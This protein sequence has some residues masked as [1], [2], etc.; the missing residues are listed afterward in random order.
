MKWVEGLS[1]SAI[2]VTAAIAAVQCQGVRSQTTTRTEQAIAAMSREVTVVINGQNPGSG[3]IVARNG[4]TY[5]VLTA[6]HAIATED[7]YQIVTADAASHPIDYRNVTKLP[8]VDLAIAK[9]TSST[10]YRVAQLGNSDQTL[11]GST[12]YVSGWPHPGRVLTDRI[13]QISKGTISGRPLTA[14]EDGYG[15][16]YTNV[17]RSGMSGGP[18]FDDN[19]RA[20]GIHGRAEG[21]T[22]Y[23][24]DTGDSVDV[25]SGFNIGIPMNAFVSLAA[26]QGLNLPLLGDNFTLENRLSGHS[27]MVLSVAVSPTGTAIASGS[28][29][30]SITI[31]NRNGQSV[32]TLTGHTNAVNSLGFSPDGETLVSGS[33]DGTVKMWNL[34][35]GEAVRSLTGDRRFVRSVAFSPD[36][37]ILATG[38]AEDANVKL[39]N[40]KTGEAIRTLTGH[41]DYVNAL[42]YSADGKIIASGS[43]DRT[44]KIWNAETGEVLRTLTGNDN[45]V[46]AVAI[47]PFGN[48]LA[49]GSGEEGIVKLWNISTGELVQTLEGHTGTVYTVAI[50]PNGHLLASGSADS[51]IK[52]WSLHSGNLLHS[53]DVRT[54]SGNPAIAFAVAFAADG[55]TL[56]SGGNDAT[57]QLWQLAKP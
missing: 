22:I 21:E 55:Q 14:L 28:K 51:T 32:R 39:W 47:A 40:A 48:L 11:E 29:D 35:T 49:S 54:S 3:A 31:W 26:T 1:V 30:G 44:I 23:N 6:K 57:V 8:G 19:G 10:P 9:F 50:D 4:N 46:T 52:I 56:V 5:S 41:R 42:A 2:A 12:I 16:I 45:R 53:L 33:E 17:T 43:S 34:G 36:G 15:L 37:N 18:V 7:E 38:S 27:A 24:P 20:I 13:F 25:K